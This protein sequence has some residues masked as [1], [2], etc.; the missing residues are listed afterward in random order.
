[1]ASIFAVL[2]SSMMFGQTSPGMMALGLARAGAVEV[3]FS[4]TY[5]GGAT[6][7]H[8]MCLEATF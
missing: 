1:M 5:V 3:R 7:Y 4:K 2:M 6:A 8:F